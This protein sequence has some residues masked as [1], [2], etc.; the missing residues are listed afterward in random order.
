M[1]PGI[2]T[3][4]MDNEDDATAF[5]KN[6][7][8]LT[9]VTPTSVTP[10]E[11][12]IKSKKKPPSSKY[13]AG[14][15]N[16]K[17]SS[18]Q[19]E[20]LDIKMQLEHLLQA[21]SPKKVYELCEHDIV[22]FSTECLRHLK[23]CNHISAILESLLQFFDRSDH[24]VLHALVQDYNYPEAAMLLLQQ[25]DS[26]VDLSLPI[27]EYPVPQPIPS[28]APYDTS[29]Q[30][31]LAVKLNA[32]LSKFSLQQVV[33][34]HCLIQKIFQFTEHNWQL[35]ERPPAVRL[36]HVAAGSDIEIITG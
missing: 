18:V 9:S 24:S 31:V 5:V 19:A 8:F 30:T 27:T 3:H 36:H 25:F 15:N 22:L 13:P 26:Q 23:E 35:I 12:S 14:Q 32:E 2:I 16:F 20:F 6:Q 17:P 28:M 4:F 10:A 29:T 7:S 33:E 11:S 1:N 34:L 21:T